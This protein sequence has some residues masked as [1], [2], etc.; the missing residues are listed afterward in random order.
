MDLTLITRLFN[1]MKNK[2]GGWG[3]ALAATSLLISCFLSRIKEN[4]KD[5]DEAK[6]E[7]KEYRQILIEELRKD[8][9]AS[10]APLKEQVKQYQKAVDTLNNKVDTITQNSKL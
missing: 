7:A 5:K 2:K 8:F 10:A 1:T 9:N 4:R 3:V 6:I